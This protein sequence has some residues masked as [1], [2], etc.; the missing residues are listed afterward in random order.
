MRIFEVV[1]SDR[2]SERVIH[3]G[4]QDRDQAERLALDEWEEEFGYID[5]HTESIQEIQ[6]R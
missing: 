4:C 2:G 6:H 3:T 5:V 1:P